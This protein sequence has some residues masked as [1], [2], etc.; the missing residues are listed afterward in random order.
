MTES[1]S[2]N[3][4]VQ[5]ASRP[6]YRCGGKHSSDD[7]KCKDWVCKACGK[8]GH[9]AHVCRSKGRST[10]KSK[11]G[12]NKRDSSQTGGEDHGTEDSSE[13]VHTLFHLKEK[14]HPPLMVTG[15]LNNSSLRT[16]MEIDTIISETTYTGLWPKNVRSPLLQSTMLLRTCTGE[17]LS[18]KGQVIV[19]VTYQDQARQLRLLV[20]C[21][22]DP[23]LLGGDFEHQLARIVCSAHGRHQEPSRHLGQPC[24][25]FQGRA[26]TGQGYSSSMTLANLLSSRLEQ[27]RMPC[28]KRWRLS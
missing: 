22:N 20:V 27:Y 15:E 9:I 1:A 26:W 19:N 10:A 18:V 3:K 5:P 4:I 7:C 23:S 11:K 24:G 21:G 13:E 25:T 17:V 12:R 28:G 2:V 16:C 6:Y 14:G 8:M